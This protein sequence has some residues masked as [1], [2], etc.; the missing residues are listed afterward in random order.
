V[1]ERQVVCLCQTR[2]R[3]TEVCCGCTHHHQHHSTLNERTSKGASLRLCWQLV[4]HACAGAA[5]GV[6]LGLDG[7]L[8][9]LLRW[10][11]DG[12][13]RLACEGVLGGLARGAGVGLVILLCGRWWRRGEQADECVR[14]C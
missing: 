12:R 10:V 5:L 2:C 7:C 1:C 13:Q 11:A 8:V 3:L 14:V 9:A 6:L 4:E